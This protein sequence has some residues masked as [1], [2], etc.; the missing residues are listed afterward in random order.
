MKML[1]FGGSGRTGQVVRN[2]ALAAGWEVEAPTH[3]DCDLLQ[4]N[5]LSDRVLSSK[6]D[7]VVNCAALSGLEA[8]EDDPLTAHLLNA[9]APSA[10]ALACRHTGARF[11]HLSTDYVLEGMRPGLKNETTRCKPVNV[12]GE[13]K[14]EGELQI[15]EALPDALI[16][17]VSWVCGNPAK[18]SFVESTLANALAARPL[19]AIADKYSMPTDAADIASA[20]LKLLPL[21]VNGILHVCSGGN[22]LSWHD[23]AT[24]VLQF[25]AEA[26]ALPQLPAI[27]RQQLKSATFFRAERPRHTAMSNEKLRSLGIA[28]PTA[29]STLRSVTLRYLQS[30]GR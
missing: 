19:A 18:A 13:S 7:A 8:C 14:R 22:P 24:L 5:L 15:T 23:C 16:L 25:A 17:R 6:A 30:I 2:A 20:I 10:M 12:Y 11:V 4:T 27:E 29:E 26:G 1:L 3:S 9:V 28:M 21:P